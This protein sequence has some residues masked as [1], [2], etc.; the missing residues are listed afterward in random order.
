MNNIGLKLELR[1]GKTIR[2][3]LDELV[4]LDTPVQLW[5]PQEDGPPFVTSLARVDEDTFTTTQ[6]PAFAAGQPLD[7]SFTMEDRRFTAHTQAV[8][9][10]VFRIPASVAQ[11]ERR[12]RYRATFD[13]AEGIEVRACETVSPPLAPGRVLAGRLVDLSLQGLRVALE[14][15]SGIGPARPLERG[16]T[17]D[18]ISIVGLPDAPTIQCQGIL[19]HTLATADGPIAGILLAGLEGPDRSTIERILAEHF[20]ATFGL[21]F[22]PKRRLAG[23]G[24]PDAAPAP[25]PAAVVL[26]LRK[27][28]CRILVIADSSDAFKGLADHLRDD[29]FKQVFEARTYLEAQALAQ[30]SPCHLVLLDLKVGGH[31]GAVILQALRRNGLLL[32]TP[33]IL[34]ADRRD[35][36]VAAS[37]EAVAAIHVHEMRAPYEEVL[38]VLHRL[39]A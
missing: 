38:P 13:R 1:D 9:A 6:A 28:V 15:L 31:S 30:A 19:A 35:P 21:A 10:G 7:L 29:G 17:L 34:V 25:Q 36:E 12:E 26:K 23:H 3:Y 5:V 39:L 24:E 18:S 2:A 32:E 11:G 22:P 27:A 33:V 20:P 4:L 16:D 8:A 37:A 14:D